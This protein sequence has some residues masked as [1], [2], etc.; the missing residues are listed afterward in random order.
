LREI[1]SELAFCRN[2]VAQKERVLESKRGS[3]RSLVADIDAGRYSLCFGSKK[4]LA[5]RPAEHNQETTPF[6]STE[7]WRKAWAVARDGQWWSVGTATKPQG[8]PEIQ[9]LPETRQLRLRLTDKMA[10]TRMDARGVPRDG[11]KQS[12]MPKRMQCRFVVLD[13]VDF[14]SHKGLVSAAL[15]GAFGRLPVSMRV[16]SRL[17]E[18][19]T[20]A[21]YVQAS[22]DVPTG[23]VQETARSRESGV[24]GLDLNARGVA[25]GVVKPDGNRQVIDGKPQRGFVVWDLK[26]KSD[27]ERKQIV[28]TVVLGLAEKAQQLGVAVAIE[29]L[30]FATK[31][32]TMRAGAV[33][34]RYNEMLSS[35]ASS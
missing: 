11:G 9:W 4:L 23:F 7:D 15:K 18:D 29:N 27:E 33:S 26:V 24:M 3:L 5:Q 13:G 17:Q 20:V 14:T 2:W 19:G 10:Y 35:L 6:A 16:L 22:V 21:W 30:D 34:K 28:G 1:P 32:L 12:D 8:N 31:K 25:W